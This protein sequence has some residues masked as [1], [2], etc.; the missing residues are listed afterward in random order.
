MKSYAGAD[1]IIQKFL[2]LALDEGRY[3]ICL[4]EQS[5][6]SRAVGYFVSDKLYVNVW[7]A[8]TV[9]YIKYC[10]RSRLEGRRKHAAR[11]LSHDVRSSA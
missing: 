4:N 1:I 2:I 3:L 10:S 7:K 6:V 11:K 5:H 8:T 9:T